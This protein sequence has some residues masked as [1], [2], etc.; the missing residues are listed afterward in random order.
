[1]E[2]NNNKI[3]QLST[4]ISDLNDD[5]EKKEKKRLKNWLRRQ[6]YKQNKRRRKDQALLVKLEEK[7]FNDLLIYNT[8]SP[9]EIYIEEEEKLN[10]ID[11]RNIIDE[12]NFEDIEQWKKYEYKIKL[13]NLNEK[14]N[15][16]LESEEDM[17]IKENKFKEYFDEKK[18]IRNFRYFLLNDEEKEMVFKGIKRRR[19]LYNLQKKLKKE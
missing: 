9:Y 3:E 18:Y 11:F 14:I 8:K 6:R 5:I 13:R 12:K 16:L 10:L 1:M 19:I 17:Q 15:N 2:N 7:K 4:N